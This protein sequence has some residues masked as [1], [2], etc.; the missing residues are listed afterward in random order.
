MGRPSLSLAFRRPLTLSGLAPR[1]QIGPGR[2]LAALPIIKSPP[3]PSLQTRYPRFGTHRHTY[4]YTDRA[5]RPRRRG[6]TELSRGRNLV[7]RP[8]YPLIRSEAQGAFVAAFGGTQGKIDFNFQ[9][10]SHRENMVETIRK[11]VARGLISTFLLFDG[12]CFFFLAR[13][14]HKFA[15]GFHRLLQSSGRSLDASTTPDIESTQ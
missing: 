6:R 3:L 15:Y 7:P 12:G 14:P 13:L 11:R 1:S 4:P 9:S 2:L 5:E 10:Y 8:W